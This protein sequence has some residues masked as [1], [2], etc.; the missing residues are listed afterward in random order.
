M[1]A[2]VSMVSCGVQGATPRPRRAPWWARAARRSPGRR[3]RARAGAYKVEIVHD[4]VA[5]TLDVNEDEYILQEALDAGIDLPHDCKL[6]VCMTC[7]AKLVSRE[8]CCWCWC[9][10]ASSGL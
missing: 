8:A 6:G 1:V 9:C 4:G 10:G 3:S 7:P 2:R 5:K